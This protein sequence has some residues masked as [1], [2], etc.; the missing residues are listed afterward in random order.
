MV[1]M[2]ADRSLC[3]IDTLRAVDL[4]CGVSLRARLQHRGSAPLPG[5]QPVSPAAVGPIGHTV[6]MSS[7]RPVPRPAPPHSG[8]SGRV[9]LSAGA[10]SGVCGLLLVVAGTFLPWLTSGGVA[11]NSY[12]VLGI[13]RRLRFVDGGASATALSLWPL[14]GTVAMAPVVAGI[15]RWWRTAAIATL[16]FGLLT[17]VGAGLVLAAA[18]GHRAAGIGLSHSGP[19]VTVTGGGI[20]VTGAVLVLLARHR[21]ERAAVRPRHPVPGVSTEP[22]DGPLRRTAH[23]ADF[24]LAPWRPAG[25][26]ITADSISAVKTERENA[27]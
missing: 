24:D 14:I 22:I 17:G 20:A 13:V 9:L 6:E 3:V 5:E 2:S 26:P 15:L 16:V 11:R 18:G 27:G 4:G 19:A 1:A 8:R 10:A 7:S 12:A 25:S 21:S 23:S